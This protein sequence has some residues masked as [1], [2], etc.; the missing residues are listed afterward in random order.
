MQTRSHW[1]TSATRAFLVFSLVSDCVSAVAIAGT[2]TA[3]ASNSIPPNLIWHFGAPSNATA[4]VVQSGS[5]G[6]VPIISGG[7]YSVPITLPPTTTTLASSQAT[8]SVESVS[9]ELAGLI[10]IIK[11]WKA[12]P[13]PLKSDTLGKI[14]PVKNDVEDLISGL[15]GGSTSSGCG[16]KRKRGALGA[17]S[18]IVNGL[19]CIDE[20]LDS[21][22]HNINGDNVDSIGNSLDDLTSEND[23]LTNDNNDH[24]SDSNSGSSV[25]TSS[26]SSPSSSSVSSCIS[27]NTA[28]QVTIQCVPTSISTSGSTISTTTCSPLTTVTASG[29]SATALT[30]TVLS[31]TSASGSQPPC[32]SDTCGDACPMNG[33]PLSG[34]SMGIVASTE[35]CASISTSTTSAL[36]TASNG[37]AGS[38]ATASPTPESIAAGQSKRSF[39]GAP[40]DYNKPLVKRALPD[41][42]PPY[43]NYVSTLNPPWISQAGDA[44]A[45]WFDY[46][47]ANSHAIAGV[48][49][50]YGCTCVIISSEKGVYVS[51]IWESP[52]F[53]ASDYTPTDDNTFTTKAFNALRDG[54]ATAQS[55]TALIGTD[56]APGP[57]NA[58]YAPKVFVVTPFTS[59]FD[60]D[61]YGITT[62]LRYETRAQQLA[63][64]VAQTLP[65]SGGTG[66][67]LGYTRTNK[68]ES[69]KNP[70]TAGRAIVEIDPFQRWVTTPHDPTSAGLQ[71]GRWR[72]WVEDQLI[73]YQDFWIP[74]QTT[75]PQGGIQGRDVGYANPCAN[76][77]SQSR[78][79]TSS[80]ITTSSSSIT[81]SSTLNC[82]AV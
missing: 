36:P 16:A 58:I 50:I 3:V 37:D 79:A 73:T 63:Q 33:G 70:G 43:S 53:T 40:V 54:T 72:L 74:H 69:T 28:L 47:L 2:G 15:G 38:G 49:G 14:K 13:T 59:K 60:Q 56:Q 8:S 62:T 71:I 46:P 23:K 18:D 48:N 26:S 27:S 67:V 12:N 81:T 76:P 34:A 82:M 29:C 61:N 31:S 39:L 25:G 9:S 57:L 30:T 7:S 45:Q 20:H 22:T 17:I 6:I 11:S 4:T 64:Q 41:V 32:A 80:S 10:P 55:I 1:S 52:V 35:N 44:A 51:H 78:S 66:L 75:P 65:G 19:S 42:T 68:Q 21:I 5:T 77:S 24:N